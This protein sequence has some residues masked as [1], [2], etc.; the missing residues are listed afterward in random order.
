MI[1][2]CV[3]EKTADRTCGLVEQLSIEKLAGCMPLQRGK[4]SA[5]SDVC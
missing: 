5:G 2:Q 4:L 1:E 3:D